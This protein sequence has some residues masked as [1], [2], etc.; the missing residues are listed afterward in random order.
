MAGASPLPPVRAQRWDSAVP[1]GSAA[2]G[3]AVAAVPHSAAQLHGGAVQSTAGAPWAAAAEAERPS[4]KGLVTRLIAEQHLRDPDQPPWLVP[5]QPT[6]D[7]VSARINELMQGA[8]QR[9]AGRPPQ[10]WG[11]PQAAPAAPHPAAASAAGQA[12]PAA[13]TG[14]TAG[15]SPVRLLPPPA[16][17]AGWNRGVFAGASPTP[18]STGGQHIA[19]PQAAAAVVRAS[20]AE[21]VLGQL[22]S[23]Q[24]SDPGPT[25]AAR[26][27]AAARRGPV[28]APPPLA[29]CDSASGTPRSLP[30]ASQAGCGSVPGGYGGA[31]VGPEQQL[32]VHPLAPVGAPAAA[33]PERDPRR[34]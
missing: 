34:L 2:S 29:P 16:L 15:G 18:S 28:P 19:A 4:F 5:E 21:P 14:R 7:E 23:A 10:S 26:R 11:P 25:A 3:A 9:A 17:R 13:A 6:A 27:A 31:L 20:S 33:A 32:V 22:A 1:A 8:A 12:V 24:H 30:S